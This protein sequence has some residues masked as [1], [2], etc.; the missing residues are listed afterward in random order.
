MLARCDPCLCP[1]RTIGFLDTRSALVPNG[2]GALADTI[3]QYPC[4]LR[5]TRKDFDFGAL[6]PS[7][8]QREEQGYTWHCS[9][10]HVPGGDRCD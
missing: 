5:L 1:F 10:D 7:G 2:Q 4:V 3:A 9:L 8:G 6:L